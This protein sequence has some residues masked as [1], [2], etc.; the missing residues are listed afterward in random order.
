MVL[1]KEGEI[2]PLDVWVNKLDLQSSEFNQLLQ[3][4][5]FKPVKHTNKDIVYRLAFV[6][7]IALSRSYAIAVPKCFEK[8][9]DKSSLFYIQQTLKKYFDSSDKQDSVQ[10]E[11][12]QNLF[13]YNDSKSKEVEVYFTLKS[14]FLN[15]GVYKRRIQ[16]LTN[17]ISRPI[18]WKKTIQKSHVYVSDDS[19]FYSNPYTKKFVEEENLVSE[20]FKAILMELTNKYEQSEIKNQ[21]LH[22]C[23]SHLTFENIKENAVSY[24]ESIRI[25]SSITFNS[26]DLLVLSILIKYL[27]DKLGHLGDGVVRLY[28]TSSFHVI[29]EHICSTIFENKYHEFASMLNQPAWVI[30]GEIYD[31]G[32]FIPDVITKKQDK[33]YIIDA[34]YYY[35]IPKSVCGVS[36]IAKQL[37]YAQIFGDKDISNILVFPS[38]N[39]YNVVNKG[40]VSI[41]DNDKVEVSEFKKQRI[42]VLELSFITAVKAYLGLQDL[43]SVREE[44]WA[45]ID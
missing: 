24:C 36:D 14:Y 43:N 17:D 31:K 12:I 2:F 33:T 26:D 23:N 28:G 8:T 7:E 9:P 38:F 13:F 4:A 30:E 16:K 21:I 39:E 37:I 10:R 29:W 6:G 3:R 15:K 25:E 18:D 41:F 20:I 40:Y 11:D 45:S 44:I 27:E 42:Q 34:K 32:N 1:L 35:P 5:V 22:H 19:A